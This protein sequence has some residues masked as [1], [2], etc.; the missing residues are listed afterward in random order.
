MDQST[1][2][3]SSLLFTIYLGV[4]SITVADGWH[5]IHGNLRE[6]LSIHWLLFSLQLCLDLFPRTLLLIWRSCHK[7][8]NFFQSEEGGYFWDG[9]YGMQKLSFVFLERRTLKGWREVKCFAP[10]SKECS[11]NTPHRFPA[12]AH[13]T[14][15]N[16]TKSI[17]PFGGRTR[18]LPLPFSASGSSV[19]HSCHANTHCSGWAAPM[20]WRIEMESCA[21]HANEITAVLIMTRFCCFIKD[22]LPTLPQT[23]HNCIFLSFCYGLGRL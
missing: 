16:R 6:S 8:L 9:C 22:S 10:F 20:N 5:Q 23:P 3:H 13:W 1:V 15:T 11:K 18:S 21:L 12:P 14:Y 19:M 4:F 17:W 7:G 2:Q